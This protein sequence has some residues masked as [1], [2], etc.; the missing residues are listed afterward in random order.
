[1]IRNI[2]VGGR[3]GVEVEGIRELLQM[4]WRVGAQNSCVVSGRRLAPGQ[5]DLALSFEQVRSGADARWTLRM[6]A[7][8]I[9]GAAGVGDDG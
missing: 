6:P 9:L 8:G 7:L 3:I 4:P 5:F 1:V 2:R